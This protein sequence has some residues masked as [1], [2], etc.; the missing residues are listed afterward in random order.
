MFIS[1]CLVYVKVACT[2][3]MVVNHRG[4]QNQN[5]DQKTKMTSIKFK[6]LNSIYTQVTSSKLLSFGEEYSSEVPKLCV[7]TIVKG[8]DD[9]FGFWTSNFR[10]KC[11]KLKV[12][13]IAFFTEVK[14]VNAST[15]YAS[16]HFCFTIGVLI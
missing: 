15:V 5:N 10:G 6:T 8:R 11:E 9:G 2:S 4:G 1:S 14:R 13:M 16:Y 3:A 7:K 12:K